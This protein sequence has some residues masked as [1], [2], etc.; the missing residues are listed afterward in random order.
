MTRGIIPDENP[1]NLQEQLLLEDAK[2]GNGIPIQGGMAEPL[3]DAPQLV[4]HYGGNPEDWVK[5]SGIQTKII[6]GMIVQIH[7]FTN[8]QNNQ[9]VEFKF[10]RTYPK[11]APKNQ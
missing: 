11:I 3:G 10:K 7:W 1:S 9:T 6:D 2:A 8:I 5:M 4:T